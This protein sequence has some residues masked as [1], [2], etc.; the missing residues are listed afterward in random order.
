MMCLLR[1]ET[2]DCVWISEV[3]FHPHARPLVFDSAFALLD[4]EGCL[5]IADLYRAAH[6]PTSSSSTRTQKELASIRRKH[7][8]PQ[9]GTVDEY[10]QM[11]RKTGVPTP[12]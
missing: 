5:I 8:C 1:G 3:V 2:S 4:P 11:V 7:L 12:S 10:T 9:L 6:D